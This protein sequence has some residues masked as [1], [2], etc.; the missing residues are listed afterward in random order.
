[1]K[2][3]LPFFIPV[4]CKELKGKRLVLWCFN[5]WPV[6]PFIPVYCFEL[7]QLMTL[8]H[9]FSGTFF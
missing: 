2:S 7:V 9:A 5:A 1:M 8:T 3:G 4:F 6:S